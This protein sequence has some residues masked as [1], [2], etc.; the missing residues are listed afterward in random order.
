MLNAFLQDLHAV[1]QRLQTY[2]ASD[3]T[4]IEQKLDEL[5]AN[6]CQLL[7]IINVVRKGPLVSIFL[8]QID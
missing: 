2:Q 6:D 3:N 8:S 5:L 7:S 1:Q 4:S